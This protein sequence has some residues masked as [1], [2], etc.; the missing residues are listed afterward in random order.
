[1]TSIFKRTSTVTG[2]SSS[3]S[4]NAVVGSAPTSP[5]LSPT[6]TGATLAGT[7][8]SAEYTVDGDN[9]TAALGLA[10]DPA[11]VL[12]DRAR[13][14]DDFVRA[15]KHHFD[16]LADAEKAMAKSHAAN[17]KEWN[18]PSHVRSL[19]FDDSS[20]V[21]AL[22][23][24]FYGDSNLMTSQHANVATSLDKQTVAA[25]DAIKKTL[26]AKVHVLLKEQKERNRERVKDKEAIVKAKELLG[27]AISFAQRPGTDA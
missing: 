2:V 1:M 13:G 16:R 12:T 23:T 18:A 3:S 21:K 5:P 8:G 7:I 19:A 26:K 4:A 24:V 9:D 10:L 15:L 27:K 22:S 20:A 17:A 6:F 11:D 25:L 14:W